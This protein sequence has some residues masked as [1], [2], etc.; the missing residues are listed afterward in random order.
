MGIDVNFRSNKNPAL[1]FNHNNVV[2][3]LINAFVMLRGIHNYHSDETYALMW[4]EFISELEFQ[5]VNGLSA[6]RTVD[7]AS[8]LPDGSIAAIE[9]EHSFKNK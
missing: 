8:L 9:V 2:H 7:G 6:T 4:K 5:R 3:N 1:Q